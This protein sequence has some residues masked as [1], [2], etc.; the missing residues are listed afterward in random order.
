MPNIERL[1]T[2]LEYV[3]KLDPKSSRWEPSGTSVAQSLASWGHAVTVFPDRFRWSYEDRLGIPI[4]KIDP[5]QR[6]AGLAFFELTHSQWGQIFRDT[7]RSDRAV[8]NLR[9][10][11]ERWERNAQH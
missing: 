3:E 5:G 7:I 1:K 8:D 4:D 2:L 11:I 6:P 10:H 9:E